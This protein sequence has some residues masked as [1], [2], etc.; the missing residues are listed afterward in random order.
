MAE[1][2]TGTVT[3]LFTDVEG[4]TKL[5]E[6]YPEA[7]RV[8]M[9]RHDEVLRGVMESSGGFVF[10]TI[11][12]A[13]CVAFPSAPHALEAALAAQRALLS[14]AQEKTGP[15]RTRMALHTGSA[16]ER[17]GD[18]FGP[19]VNRIARLLSAGHGGQ[20]L[21]SS[22]T[23]ELVRDA[24]PEQTSLRDLGERRLKDLARN[25]VWLGIVTTYKGDDYEEAAGY[26]EEGFGLIREVGDWEWVAY[27]LDS[28][29]VVA[30]AKGQGERAARLWGAA[31]ALRKSI[32]APLHPTER[33][34][35]D[36]SVATARAQ[37]NETAW[38]AAWAEGMAMSAEE[39]A[40]YALGEDDR[41]RSD[42][43]SE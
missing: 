6:R 27:S 14:E 22:A 11:G 25:F 1:P 24:L 4:S 23:K 30:G 21:L 43:L 40:E 36:R 12:D 16:D 28:F 29:A 38:E 26:L 37:L 41:A 19:P 33:P 9:A 8:T 10:K 31:E 3:F 34:D 17:C 39:A 13:F 35:Y 5:W 15:L 42:H 7:M 18:Y 32:G 20:I 2:P